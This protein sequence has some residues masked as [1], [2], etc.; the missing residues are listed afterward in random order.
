MPKLK[1]ADQSEV[2]VAADKRL[3]LAIEEAG[4]NIGHR[5]G[6]YARCTTC[7]VTFTEGEPQT[8]TAAEYNKLKDANLL[9]QAR[10]ACQ[11]LCQHDMALSVLMTKES[12][13]WSDTGPAPQITVTPEPAEFQPRSFYESKQE[14]SEPSQ[15][16][17]I[18]DIARQGPTFA[19]GSE[20]FPGDDDPAT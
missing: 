10:L 16:P 1:I 19:G 5:C 17:Q 11:I 2:E 15:T 8:Y 9:G 4:V 3:V 7:R 12:E 14:D 13:G 20:N 18:A 6:G